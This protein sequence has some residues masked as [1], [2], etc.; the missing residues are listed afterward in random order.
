MLRDQS[1]NKSTRQMK[2]LFTLALALLVTFSAQAVTNAVQFQDVLAEQPAL[3]GLDL[4]ADFDAQA[5]LDLTPKKVREMTGERL[6]I[7]G[8]LALKAAQK[9]YKKQLKKGSA[10]DIPKGLYI[11]GA[12]FGWGWLLMGLMDDFE[13]NNWWVNLILSFLCLVPGIIHAF[14]KMNEYY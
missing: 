10:T 2:H 14:I 11:V 5:F 13:G 4:G 9:S 12:L 6:G 7:K 3:A 1:P 8:S